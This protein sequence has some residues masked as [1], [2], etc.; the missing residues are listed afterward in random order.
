MAVAKNKLQDIYNSAVARL[1][2]LEDSQRHALTQM[3]EKHDGT[4]KVARGDLS[5]NLSSREELLAQEIQSFISNS[6]SRIQSAVDMQSSLTNNCLKRCTQRLAIAVR[7]FEEELSRTKSRQD[8]LE[9]DSLDEL[10]AQFSSFVEQSL[11]GFLQVQ[12]EWSQ[13]LR[14]KHADFRSD[15][16]QAIVNTVANLRQYERDQ[17]GTMQS[18]AM[19][20]M[21]RLKGEA[22]KLNEQLRAQYQ[23]QADALRVKLG[24]FDTIFQRH[25]NAVVL[26]AETQA[27]ESSQELTARLETMYAVPT[28]E[29]ADVIAKHKLALQKSFEAGTSML[30]SSLVNTQTE[31]GKAADGRMSVIDA[32]AKEVHNSISLKV[33]SLVQQLNAS[34]NA[35]TKLE[36]DLQTTNEEVS[37]KLRSDFAGLFESF[38]KGM[39]GALK[40]TMDELSKTRH[41]AG[42][43]VSAARKES[44]SS[45]DTLSSAV[46]KE[47]EQ[48]L[49]EI[50]RHIKEAREVAVKKVEQAATAPSVESIA[51]QPQ[52]IGTAFDAEFWS[53]IAIPDDKEQNEQPGSEHE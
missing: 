53:D 21:E 50:L 6:V 49:S 13:R 42:Q 24:E 43:E 28:A 19:Q 11:M 7:K 22:E 39:D 34:L 23:Q 29:L 45:I 51:K 33:E 4:E 27:K 14:D 41:V 46:Q 2:E 20:N 38:K 17:T 8:V 36:A 26:S 18:T 15:L 9:M 32:R 47:I 12:N 16:E 44:Q 40:R 30:A 25:H 10:S 37:A 35:S 31:I 1:T 3:Y 52:P 48:S 5:E